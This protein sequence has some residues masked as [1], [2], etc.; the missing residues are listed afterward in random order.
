MSKL[1][2]EV[3]TELQQA[4]N[5]FP[6]WPT[7]PMHAKAILGEE[8]GELE[9]AILQCIYEPEKATPQDV[10]D[11]AIQVAAMAIRF[12]A[13]FDMYSFEACE[14]HCQNA[15]LSEATEL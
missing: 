3:I 15:L 5:K 8:V 6:T 12:L 14:Q 7:D 11:E 4:A 2:Q 10:Y 9:K 1:I 13:S